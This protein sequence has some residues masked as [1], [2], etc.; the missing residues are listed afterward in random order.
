[1]QFRSASSRACNVQLLQTHTPR[2]AM[3][4]RAKS[5]RVYPATVSELCSSWTSATGATTNCDVQST[6]GCDSQGQAADAS[7][8]DRSHQTLKALVGDKDIRTENGDDDLAP[9]SNKVR[10]SGS[11]LAV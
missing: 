7:A 11:T 1:M 2:C 10:I 4:A 3:D 9:A 8:G 5:Q 6:S